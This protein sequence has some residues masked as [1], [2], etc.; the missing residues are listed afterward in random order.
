MGRLSRIAQKY[1]FIYDDKYLFKEKA[2]P[3]GPDLPLTKK[4]YSSKTMFISFEDRIPSQKNPAYKDYCKTV[5]INPSEKDP[6]ILAATLGQKGPS[7][8]V[9]SPVINENLSSID[10]K[11]FRKKLNLT[12]REFAELFDF[13]TAT[14]TRIEKNAASAKEAL[15]RLEIYY[16]FPEVALYEIH[17]NKFKI[18]D[19][20]I[21]YV[22][23]YLKRQI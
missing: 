19:K 13:S 8:F 18:I 17:K 22:T 12:V 7:S 16:N 5:G 20:K 14:V 3:L 21:E 10:I 9:F 6:L 23:E 15:K 11:N 2:I 1:V 4:K